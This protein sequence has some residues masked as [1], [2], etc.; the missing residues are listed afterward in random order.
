MP[1][2][3][4]AP[5]T[6]LFHEPTKSAP[7]PTLFHEPTEP[8]PVPVKLHVVVIYRPPGQ[9]GTLLEELDGLLSSFPED[10]SPLI[11]VGD[12][13]IHLNKPHAV[14]FLSLLVYFDLKSTYHHLHSQ[15]CQPA[16]LNLHAIV[17]Q[18]TFW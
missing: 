12:L 14:H 4:S 1:V 6:A 9:F 2:P 18:T 5:E 17:L 16:G 7:E 8:A 11:V 10:G 3:E 13:N 15:I